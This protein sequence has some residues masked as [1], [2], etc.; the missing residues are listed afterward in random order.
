MIRK[1]FEVWIEVLGIKIS[2]MKKFS[3]YRHKSAASVYMYKNENLCIKDKF[4]QFEGQG[5]NFLLKG[6]I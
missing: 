1:T 3:L 2:K 6:I 4:Y 5:L